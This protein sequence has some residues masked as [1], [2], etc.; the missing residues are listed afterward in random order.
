M[1]VESCESGNNW[2]FIEPN[3]LQREGL[4]CWEWRGR[5]ITCELI[6]GF[7]DSLPFAFA[8]ELQPFV[9]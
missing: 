6:A 8:T 5:I 3:V 9:G 1:Q 2:L 4:L 7:L